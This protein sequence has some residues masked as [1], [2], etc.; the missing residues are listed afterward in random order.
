MPRD[1]VESWAWLETAGVGQAEAVAGR[2]LVEKR[3][4]GTE[5]GNDRLRAAAIARIIAAANQ[6]PTPDGVPPSGDGS[7]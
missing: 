4:N 5:I 1:Y 3:M 6:S 7:T 2:D